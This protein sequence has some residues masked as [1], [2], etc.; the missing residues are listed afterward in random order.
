MPHDD[1]KQVT[2]HIFP[3]KTCFFHLCNNE[4][5]KVKDLKRYFAK[6]VKMSDFGSQV[7]FYESV[8]ISERNAH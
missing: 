7:D 8:D 3:E 2:S 5:E 6:N 4:Q 1:D